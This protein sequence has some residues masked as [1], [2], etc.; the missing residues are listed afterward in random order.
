MHE[1][2][3]LRKD[4]SASTF[5]A[6]DKQ[7]YYLLSSHRESILRILKPCSQ[8]YY[9]AF[10]ETIKLY[11]RRILAK[12]NIDANKPPNKNLRLNALY[13]L[14]R[15]KSKLTLLFR[16]ICYIV[17]QLPAAFTREMDTLRTLSRIDRFTLTAYR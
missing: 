5:T 15:D 13:E 12:E 7:V 10:N 9:F 1:S 8:A 11:T 4:L 6:D 14:M 2:L 17:F 3:G 16:G